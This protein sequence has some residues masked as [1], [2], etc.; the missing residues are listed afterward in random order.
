MDKPHCAVMSL[1]GEV[2]C[3][4]SLNDSVNSQNEPSGSL[5]YRMRRV[6]KPFVVTTYLSSCWQAAKT[7]SDSEPLCY[8]K[9]YL[10][11]YKAIG[12]A[13]FL[14]TSDYLYVS[15]SASLSRIQI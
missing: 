10:K 13:L 6:A 9:K 7:L 8:T 4:N 5:F 1:R 12:F 3:S 14:P 2:F 15:F 11:S